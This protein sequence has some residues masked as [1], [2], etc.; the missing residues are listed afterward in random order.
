MGRVG[1]E[2]QSI[3]HRGAHTRRAEN[4][5]SLGHSRR[6]PEARRPA[7]G[8]AAGK[9]RSG[10]NR[11]RRTDRPD[12]PDAPDEYGLCAGEVPGNG[13][14]HGSR[15]APGHRHGG[16]PLF[17][18]P[19]GGSGERGGS[20]PHKPRHGGAAVRLPALC[21]C[22]PFPETDSAGRVCPGGAERFPCERGGA[23]A[24]VSGGCGVYIVYGDGAVTSAAA[25]RNA[26][27]RKFPAPA[28]AGPLPCMCRLT[29]F[30]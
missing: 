29:I 19:P 30:I 23:G 14:G 1:T 2:N 21:L 16:V 7:P 18:R 11:F 10:K 8:A 15:P 12:Q 24:G 27:G 28:A 22:K 6:R 3:L 26:P 9:K 17:H 20:L 5:E 25:G 4:R 13:G